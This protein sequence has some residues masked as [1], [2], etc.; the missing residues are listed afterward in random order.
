MNGDLEMELLC[1]YYLNWIDTDDVFYN[2]IIRYL[3]VLR[4]IRVFYQD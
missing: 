4:K 2:Y 3:K 1:Y